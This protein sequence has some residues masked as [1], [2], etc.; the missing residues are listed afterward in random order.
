MVQ[1]PLLDAATLPA[2]AGGIE[3]PMALHGKRAVVVVATG[4]AADPRGSGLLA[5]VVADCPVAEIA[6]SAILRGPAG[7]G[8][9]IRFG[10]WWL[11]RRDV[12]PEGGFDGPGASGESMA[13]SVCEGACEV[14]V[15]G[16]RSLRHGAARARVGNRRGAREVSVRERSVADVSAMSGGARVAAVAAAMGTAEARGKK[17]RR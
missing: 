8:I 11:L 17:E 12:Q 13:N 7:G 3:V 15:S 5:P 2:W 1:L 14:R 9:G 6:L 10:D 4:L 16:G